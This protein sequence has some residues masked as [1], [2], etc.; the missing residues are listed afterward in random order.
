MPPT[1]WHGLKADVA[2]HTLRIT[3]SEEPSMLQFVQP[4][5]KARNPQCSAAMLLRLVGFLEYARQR[6]N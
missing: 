5:V 3:L 1:E 2:T 4:Q 6:C